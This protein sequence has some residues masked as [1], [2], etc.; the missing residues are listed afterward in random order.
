MD[1][2]L[3]GVDPIASGES[4]PTGGP[5]LIQTLLTGESPIASG[6]SFPTPSGVRI[7]PLSMPASLF[8]SF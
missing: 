1:Q 2:T 7:D 5:G 3:T 8:V 6:E 4:F